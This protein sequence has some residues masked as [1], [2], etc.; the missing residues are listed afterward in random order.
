MM[1]NVHNIEMNLS[2]MCDGRVHYRIL[3]KCGILCYRDGNASFTR[4]WLPVE[5]GRVSADGCVYACL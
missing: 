3:G 1:S 2:V 4:G 5:G